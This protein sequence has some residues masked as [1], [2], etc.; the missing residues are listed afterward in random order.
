MRNVTVICR[1]G[2]IL[3]PCK[4]RCKHA[5]CR[6]AKKVARATCPLCGEA[7]GYLNGVS[8]LHPRSEDRRAWCH[9]GCL[10]QKMKDRSDEAAALGRALKR[11]A[12]RGDAAVK[13]AADK[14]ADFL[15]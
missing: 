1:P 2:T 5:A 14:L 11:I 12:A 13:D 6:S 4:G 15:K 8:E 9:S 10:E 7:I 3:G